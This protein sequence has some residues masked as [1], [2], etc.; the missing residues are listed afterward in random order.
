[1]ALAYDLCGPLH[2]LIKAE[3][4][5]VL[6]ASG[7]NSVDSKFQRKMKTSEED[8]CLWIP[9]KERT[10]WGYVLVPA[11]GG[12]FKALGRLIPRDGGTSSS[13]LL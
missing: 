1:M 12:D 13:S 8:V 7:N 2:L 9:H 5:G 11:S 4:L 10:L 6:V 3:S